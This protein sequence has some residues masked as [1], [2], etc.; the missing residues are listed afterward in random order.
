[1]YA[2]VFKWTFISVFVSAILIYVVFQ[3]DGPIYDGF[4]QTIIKITGNFASRDYEYKENPNPIG[5][6][7]LLSSLIALFFLWK[8]ID[9]IPF[10]IWDV[11]LYTAFK[12]SLI[13]LF[14][15]FLHLLSEHVMHNFDNLL[16][17][18]MFILIVINSYIY[19][20]SAVNICRV[21]L[22]LSATYGIR[23]TDRS[24][25]YKDIVKSENIIGD[26]NEREQ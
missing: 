22:I 25:Y 14:L 20:L 8:Y 12:L 23:K 1:M 26:Y 2:K 16:S 19:A 15:F 11:G 6:F 17:F 18:N 9:Y 3:Q 13:F 7:F 5:V 4:M 10:N 21:L 24:P